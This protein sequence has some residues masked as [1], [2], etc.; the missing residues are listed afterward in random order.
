MPADPLL[1]FRGRVALYHILR[2]LGVGPGDEVLLQ[3]FTCV[4]VP[5]AIMA[6]GAKPVWVDIAP[7]GV[8][9]DASDLASRITPRTKAVVVQ[10]TFGIPAD[11]DAIEPVAVRHG[12]PLIEDCCH[13]LASTHRG[14][15]LGELGAASFW[16]YEWGKPVI[17][18]LGG[19]ARFN[20]EELRSRAASSHAA[21]FRPPPARKS[22]LIASQFLMHALAYGPRRFWAVRSVFHALGRAGIAQPNYN[23]VG[24][25]VAMASDFRWQMCG[26]SRGRLAAARARAAGFLPE[27]VRQADRYA[28]GLRFAAARL[29]IVPDQAA[30]VYSRFPVFVGQKD[31]LLASA[32]S[33]NLEI[34]GW[35]ATPVH[36]LAG[37]ELRLVSYPSGSCPRAEAAATSLVSLPLHQKVTPSFQDELIGLINRHAS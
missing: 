35:F 10:H 16:S 26:F 18:G 21:D 37:D 14:R 5:E 8:N 7:G 31:R 17:A 23:P 3:A 28:A 15:P 25:G 36:P 4:A 20:A 6:T 33:A 27:R 34:A 13:S 11:M 1:Y 19:E 9:L 30:A 32:R 12:L 22:V 2:L 24:H 29:P